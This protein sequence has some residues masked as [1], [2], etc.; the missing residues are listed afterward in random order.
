ML[1]RHMT[2]PT[3]L[4]RIT[5][6][7]GA[8]SAQQNMPPGS[9]WNEREDTLAGVDAHFAAV[10]EDDALEPDDFLAVAELIARA[11]DHIAR[12]QRR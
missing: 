11:G 5:R 8:A 1:G 6:A 3:L 10:G 9:T 12:L 7:L 4:R 2:A